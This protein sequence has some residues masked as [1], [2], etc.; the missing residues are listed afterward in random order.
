NDTALRKSFA[1]SWVPEPQYRGTWGIL[2]SCLLTLLLCVYNAIHL[3]VPSQDEGLFSYRY[4]R[5]MAKW[6]FIA[7]IAPEVVLVCAY[8][9][10]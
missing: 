3:N 7:L 8:F 6:A 9:Q 5:R 10:W 1:P 2:Y 4:Y